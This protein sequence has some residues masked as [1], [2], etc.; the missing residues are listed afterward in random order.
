MSDT[1][2][3]SVNEQ[4]DMRI[5]FKRFY[6]ADRT[7][8]APGSHHFLRRHARASTPDARAS[9]LDHPR[10]LRQDIR[11]LEK[12]L[13]LGGWSHKE[14]QQLR[15]EIQDL[16]NRRDRA[17]RDYLFPFK[18]QYG[19]WQNVN[20]QEAQLRDQEHGHDVEFHDAPDS[21]CFDAWPAAGAPRS[22]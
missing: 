9:T 22:S 7:S 21:Q 13:R 6:W 8:M 4:I 17:G 5:H 15:D 2:I 11:L 20:A 19:E 12:K 3:E 18:D 1:A 16:N 14:R 10:H